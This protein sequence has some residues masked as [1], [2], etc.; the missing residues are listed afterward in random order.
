MLTVHNT[1]GLPLT[2][3]AQILS[4]K[5]TNSRP[6][7]ACQWACQSDGSNLYHTKPN[8]HIIVHMYKCMG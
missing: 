8:L 4:T 7:P 6:H 5:I 1:V 2:L 3:Y